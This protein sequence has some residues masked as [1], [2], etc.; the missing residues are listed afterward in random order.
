[1]TAG[2]GSPEAAS[3]APRGVSG[4]IPV[5]VTFD[6]LEPAEVGENQTDPLLAHADPLGNAPEVLS[7]GPPLVLTEGARRT[8]KT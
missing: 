8:R 2:T 4:G 1:M 7:V 3:E 5:P 6:A